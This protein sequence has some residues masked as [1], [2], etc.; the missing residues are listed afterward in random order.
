MILGAGGLHVVENRHGHGRIE[1]LGTQPIASVEQ[2]G[3]LPLFHKGRTHIQIK[4]LT[5]CP[6]F[7]GAVQNRDGFG[8]LGNR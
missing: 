6:R 4:G 7:L 3:S 1:L 2:L 5:R 8:G